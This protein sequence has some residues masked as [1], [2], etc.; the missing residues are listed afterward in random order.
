MPEKCTGKARLLNLVRTNS[1]FF[2]HYLYLHSVILGL[3]YLNSYFYDTLVSLIERYVF[4]NL[5]IILSVYPFFNEWKMSCH[6]A[7]V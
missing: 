3:Q 4:D 1:S 7:M 2:E 5:R 6:R